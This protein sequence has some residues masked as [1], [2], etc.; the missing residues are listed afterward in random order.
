MPEAAEDIRKCA[1]GYMWCER[2]QG[3]TGSPPLTNTLSTLLGNGDHHGSCIS[4]DLVTGHRSE[5]H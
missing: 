1:E 4:P 2:T 3:A 5:G